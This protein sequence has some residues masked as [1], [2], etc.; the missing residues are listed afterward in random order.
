MTTIL[1]VDGMSCGHCEAAVKKALTSL[2]GV[3]AVTVDLAAKSV[4]VTHDGNVTA[5]VLKNQI[6]EQGYEVID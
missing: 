4:T 5:D 6:E 1:T 3:T 2:S